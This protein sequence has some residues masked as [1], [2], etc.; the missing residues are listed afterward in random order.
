MK[1]SVG[2]I[3]FKLVEN[4]TFQVI[5]DKILIGK[6]VTFNF[7]TWTPLLYRLKFQSD[8]FAEIL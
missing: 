8:I 1:M 3:I 4:F 6:Q 5:E 2:F 7:S